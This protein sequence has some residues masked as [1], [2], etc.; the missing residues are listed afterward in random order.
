MELEQ[1]ARKTRIIED[2]HDGYHIA[3]LNIDESTPAVALDKSLIS[4]FFDVDTK[5]SLTWF[6]AASVWT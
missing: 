2:S 4:T 3:A 1:C 5:E 6:I